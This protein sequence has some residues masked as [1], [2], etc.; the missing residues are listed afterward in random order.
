M[1]KKKFLLGLFLTIIGLFGA[2]IW[3]SIFNCYDCNYSELN[4][5]TFYIGLVINIAI[6]P[7]GL[8]IASKSVSK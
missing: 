5:A 3:L 2:L 1:N 4:L 8:V 6:I 7:L